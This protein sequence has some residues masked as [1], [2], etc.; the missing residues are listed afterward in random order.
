MEYSDSVRGTKL[1]KR[2]D[3]SMLVFK[4]LKQHPKF[5]MVL[6]QTDRD[7][8]GKSKKGTS[9]GTRTFFFFRLSIRNQWFDEGNGSGA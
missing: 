5:V 9:D 1:P 6:L 2:I 8:A 3:S 7:A 4:F